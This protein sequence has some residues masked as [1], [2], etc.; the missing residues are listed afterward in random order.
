MV[1]TK[2][3]VFHDYLQGERWYGPLSNNN[4]GSLACT[5]KYTLLWLLPQVLVINTHAQAAVLGFRRHSARS[6]MGCRQ[7]LAGTLL[8]KP[9]AYCVYVGLRNIT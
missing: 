1:K 2:Q 3:V 8:T 5:H 4:I 7:L 6:V 9:Q